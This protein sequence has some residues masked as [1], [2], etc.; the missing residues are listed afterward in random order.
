ME[1]WEA[2]RNLRITWEKRSSVAALEIEVHELDTEGVILEQEGARVS[3]VEV[4]HQPVEPAFGFIFEAAGHKLAVSGDTR[5][6]ENLVEAARDADV[7]VHEVFDHGSMAITGTRT[8]QGLANVAAYHTAS[9]DVGRV[10]RQ[11]GVGCLVLTHIVP[12]D[13][14]RSKLLAHARAEYAGPV[15]VGEDLMAIDVITRTV[16]WGDVNFSLPAR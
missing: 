8:E 13:V 6:C 2:E 10:A 12:P 11:A 9:T 5:Y 3:M 15:I 7:L 1:V 4:E 14:D 16:Q